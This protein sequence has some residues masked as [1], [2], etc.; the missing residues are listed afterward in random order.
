MAHKVLLDQMGLGAH[1]GHLVIQDKEG[2]L[3]QLDNRGQEVQMVEQ[4]L[5][6]PLVQTD[7]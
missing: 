3:E 5:Q 4:D 1:W 2:K 7:Q 6:G